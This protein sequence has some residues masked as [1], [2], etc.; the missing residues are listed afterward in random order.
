M[1]TLI[2]TTVED[3]QD[4]LDT[5]GAGA[6]IRIE[7]DSVQTMTGATEVTTQAVAATTTQYEYRDQTGVQGTSWYRTRFSIA[8]PTLPAHYSAY[9]TPRR[10]AGYDYTWPALALARMGKSAT[11]DTTV[12]QS[13]ADGINRDLNRRLGYFVG[14]S[15]DTLRVLHGD[16]AQP[17][18]Y[19]RRIYIPGGIRT[20]T[21]VRIATQ[22]GGTLAAATLADFNLGP[23]AWEM[24]PDEPYQYVELTTIPTGSWGATISMS[25]DS[26]TP[27]PPGTWLIRLT[28]MAAA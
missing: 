17:H 27:R 21:A 10:G 5:Y 14:P 7:R 18:C 1:A 9:S 24:P 19:G 3:P 6:L 20:L 23:D 16:N 25:T 11:S 28:R 22:T 26:K 12:L 13:L 8:T 2:R 4:T 15:D